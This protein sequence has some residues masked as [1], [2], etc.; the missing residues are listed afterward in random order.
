MPV[1]GERPEINVQ[2]VVYATDF[3]QA[4]EHAGSYAKLLAGAFAA[5]LFVTHA[6]LLSQPALE[7]EERSRG[8][9]RQREDLEAAL[10]HRATQLSTPNRAAAP[11]LLDGNPHEAIPALADK[12]APALIVLGTHGAGRVEH[13]LIGSVAEKIL[14]CS[15]WPCLTVGPEVGPPIAGSE[16]FQHI[17]YATDFSPAAANAAAYALAFAE[18]ARGNIDTINV[19]PEDAARNRSELAQLESHYRRALEELVPEQARDFC[20]PHTF[21]EVGAAHERIRK[22]ISERGID[23]LVLGIRKTSHISLAMRTSSAYRLIADAP[24]PVLTIIG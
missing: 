1:I 19:I 8:R 22:H 18:S 2:S 12:N 7:A 10:A 16:L 23:L 4:S 20:N 21:V 6:F 5:R 13:G 24:C 14:R 17:L 9:S 15:R 3:S 11:V